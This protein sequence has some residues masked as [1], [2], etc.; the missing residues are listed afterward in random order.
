[1]ANGFWLFVVAGGAAL[2]GVA[3][4]FGMF[5]ENRTRAV[6]AMAGAFIVAVCAV[7]LG[8]LISTKDTAP[9]VSPDVHGSQYDLP[10][11]PAERRDPLKT[12]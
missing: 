12:P 8:A 2:L 3:L 11:Q 7:G 10:A 1:M 9:Q 4:A 6:S 5:K